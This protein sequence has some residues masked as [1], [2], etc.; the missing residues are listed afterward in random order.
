M[1][2][3]SNFRVRFAPSPTGNPH[4]GN[5]R[6]ALFN[7]LYARHHGGSF[8]LRIEDTDKERSRKEYET[9]ILNSLQWMGMD[10]DEE[11]VYQSANIE[12]HIAAAN[13]LL[14]EGKAYRCRCTPEDL[15]A[16]RDA[17]MQTGENP[18]YDRTCR[19]KNYEDDGTPFCV[20]LKTP[21]DG[22]NTIHDP[23]RGDIVIE[24]KE[25]DDLVI[26]RTDGSPTYNFAVV[27]DDHTMG[28]TH[29]IRGDDHLRNTFRQYV[30]YEL[31][32]Y[33]KPVFVHLPQ[34]LGQ[35]KSRLSKRHGATGVL[36]YKEQGYLPE[37]L[38]NYLARLGWGHGD[39]EFFTKQDLI[40]LFTLESC[41]KSAATFDPQKLLWLN[42][43]HIRTLAVED[44]A[45]RF[46]AYALD[47]GLLTEAQA[48]NA[49]LLQK[50]AQCTQV[51]SQTLQEMYEMVSFVFATE[52]A[53]PEDAAKI[54]KPEVMEA[55]A[56]LARFAGENLATPLSHQ[57]W[58]NAFKSI[59]EQ[60]GI[61]MKFFASAV[62]LALTASTV[63]P[64]IF[65]ILDLLGN[66]TVQQRLLHAV[67]YARSLA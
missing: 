45:N 39:Q 13:R 65:D 24:N 6:T 9:A 36:E 11:P 3:D 35:D 46:A 25:L 27:I 30:L 23:I 66:Q 20:R 32:G 22:A 58:E 4:V 59:M 42:G 67:E 41:N 8:L 12:S 51:R 38:M 44:L 19:E 47:K 7:Y 31:L 17:Q 61:K 60:R 48:R 49:S 21:L 55:V 62:R 53:F 50:I 15:E 63:S 10:W 26:L 64:P 34:I 18:M 43:E 29:V 28:I 37:A 16:R 5:F 56:D 57:D 1:M 52:L 54:F 33:A 14:A 2:S 40:S